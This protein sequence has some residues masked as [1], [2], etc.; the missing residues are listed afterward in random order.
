MIKSKTGLGGVRDAHVEMKSEY[1]TLV[2]KP[3]MYRPLER[4]N[5]DTLY[6]QHPS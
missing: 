6:S 1:T 4:T 2:R 3:E 5:S